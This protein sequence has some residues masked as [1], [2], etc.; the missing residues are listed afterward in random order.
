VAGKR[1]SIAK[2]LWV[3]LAAVLL[4]LLLGGAAFLTRPP[5]GQAPEGD[6]LRA[7]RASAHQV[8]GEFRNE[9]PTPM[10]VEGQNMASILWGNLT[11]PAPRR[12]PAQPL[13]FARID[14]KALPRDRDTVVWLGHSSFYVQLAGQRILI[15]PVFSDH[16]SP[17][18]FANK[19]FP[20]ATPY[21]PDDVP[22]IDLLLITHDH[23]DHL[24]HDSLVVLAPRIRQ[25]I[26]GLGVGSHLPGW[27]FAPDQIRQG[28]WGDSF[29]INDRLTVHVLSARHY[30]GRALERN[31]TLWV[32]FALVAPQRRLY[33][34]GDSGYGPHFRAIGERFGGFDFVAL[35]SG[36]YDARWPLI[37]MNPEEA[38]QAAVDLKAAVLL[39]AHVGRFAMARHAWD[40]PLQRIVE[41]SRGRPYRLVMPVTGD[42]IDLREERVPA[43]TSDV[44]PIELW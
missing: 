34:S 19:A 25:V 44:M 10:F 38:A 26:T 31:R 7:I 23:W 32:S 36:Q 5:F 30:S 9:L 6:V 3:V 18:S 35:D 2:L 41:A 1:V 16:A 20:G 15:D 29:E 14:L 22:D 43:P 4:V 8:D 28:D 12:E 17:V 33:F 27:G 13:P 24:D 42:A 21:A 11:Q 40:E 39:P 37:H